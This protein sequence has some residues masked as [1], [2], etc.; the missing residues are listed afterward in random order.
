M[1][2]E[3]MRRAALVAVVCAACSVQ[4]AAQSSP[5]VLSIPDGPLLCRVDTT[6]GEF[7]L[8]GAK[9][10][11]FREGQMPNQRRL[12][13]SI[14]SAGAPVELIVTATHVHG[15][16]V[17]FSS[18]SMHVAG[19]NT[20]HAF[21]SRSTVAVRDARLGD[22]LTPESPATPQATAALQHLAEWLATHHCSGDA[23][24]Q[25]VRP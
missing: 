15:D 11:E 23:N 12:T 21:G 18:F 9:T 7:A 24:P 25:P 4:A 3:S 14:D 16:S 8:P 17:T 6:R 22:G 2:I 5:D 20:S 1:R 13:L 19:G 10:F